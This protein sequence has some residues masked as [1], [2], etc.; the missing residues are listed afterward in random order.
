[1][2]RHRR[3]LAA[4]VSV[5]A[6]AATVAISDAPADGTRAE[7]APVARSD[8][9]SRYLVGRG[10]ADLTGE[11]AEAGMLGYADTSQVSAGIHQRQRVRAFVVVDRRTGQRVVHVTADL[12]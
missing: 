11:V 6:V 10:I 4:L 7:A 8:A 9:A 1:V 2:P 5:C 3:L 12:P